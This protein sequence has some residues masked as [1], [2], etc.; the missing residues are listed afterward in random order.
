MLAWEDAVDGPRPGVLVAHTIAG[1]TG[2][3]ESRAKQLAEFGYVGFAID[4]YGKGTQTSDFDRNKAMMDALRDDR[5]QL[6]ERLLAALACLRRQPEVNG[7]QTAAIGFCFGGLSVLDIARTGEDI[8][9]VVSLHGIFEPPGNTAG[10][11]ISA[12]VLALH[13]WE[14]PLA[15]PEN[16]EA[17]A[18]EL[19]AMGADW[20]IHAYGN[21]THAFT[22]PNADDWEGGKKYSQDADRRSWVATQ[23]FLGE[24]FDSPGE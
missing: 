21:T 9:G 18:A 20:Q 17:L 23:N 1:R 19:T 12:K 10:N 15:T 24:L 16:V 22:N 6:Q 14:D 11:S 8:A 3:E 13:G 4:V 5:Q 7:D 2:L